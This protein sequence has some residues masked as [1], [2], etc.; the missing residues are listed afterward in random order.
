VDGIRLAM[1]ANGSDVGSPPVGVVPVGT[2]GVVPFGVTTV[3]FGGFGALNP[4]LDGACPGRYVFGALIGFIAFGILAG[5]W[6]GPPGPWLIERP[7]VCTM[8]LSNPP[9]LE[10]KAI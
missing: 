3:T 9:P 7:Y 5:T 8:F 10:T 6:R 2:V 4:R 1:N